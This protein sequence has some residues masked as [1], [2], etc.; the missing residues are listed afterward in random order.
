MRMYMIPRATNPARARKMS[1][2]LLAARLA[3]LFP[4]DVVRDAEREVVRLAVV[5]RA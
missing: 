5:R 1:A 2:S 3:V 4:R